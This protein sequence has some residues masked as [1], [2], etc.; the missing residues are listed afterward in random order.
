MKKILFFLALSVFACASMVS[1]QPR[2][3]DK[4]TTP[5]AVKPAP[6]SFAAKYEG[7]MFGFSKKEEGTLKFDD[8]NARL[9]FFSKEQKELFSIPYKSMLIVSPQSQSVQSTT[10]KVVSVVP[11][12]GLLG[13]FIKEKRRYLII[14]FDD[15]DVEAKGLVN[16]KIEDKELLDSVITAL[17]T[18]AQLKPRGDAYYRPKDTAKADNDK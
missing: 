15:P 1:A 17:G 13:G 11:Y 2:P 12:A 8:Q 3:V 9:I 6:S 14:N 7:G 10:G 16:F 4:T 18:K 5:A